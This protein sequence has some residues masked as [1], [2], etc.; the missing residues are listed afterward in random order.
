MVVGC[1]YV[2]CFVKE[3]ALVIG[4]FVRFGFICCF[5][6]SLGVAVRDLFIV[7]RRLFDDCVRYELW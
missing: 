5:F 4:E 3:R 2:R 7:G 1:W 6:L